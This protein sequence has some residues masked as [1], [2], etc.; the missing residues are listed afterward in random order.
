HVSQL[1]K[2]LL[3][4]LKCSVC[5]DVFTDPVST[6]CGH[7]FC[8]IL[9]DICDESRLKALKSR[10]LCQASYCKTHLDLHQR[11]LS[12]KKHKLMDPVKNMK[13]YICQKHERPLELFCRDDQTYVCVFCTDGDHKTHNTVPL[14]EENGK[15]I[16]SDQIQLM[17]T[18]KDV[19]Q[20]IQDKNKKIQD[21]IYFTELRK[22][23][24]RYT[25][26]NNI[27]NRHR[28]TLTTANLETHVS[29][30]FEPFSLYD[31]RSPIRSHDHKNHHDFFTMPIVRLEQPKITQC[32]LG[33][34]EV[35]R[36][37]N[38]K[39]FFFFNGWHH[40]INH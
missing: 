28:Q 2:L 31:I 21:I 1:L 20:M 8:K 26:S 10:L 15:S 14:E 37:G 33:L 32:V 19:H 23:S 11:V 36:E 38:L 29:A 18:Q 6:P 40:L 16:F 7:K 27:E 35:H 13:D 30:V 3:N 4:K 39:Q 17:K 24:L 34:T 12:L 22:V 25:I 9:C 5:L